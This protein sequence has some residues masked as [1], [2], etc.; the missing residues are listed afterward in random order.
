MGTGLLALD[1]TI[2]KDGWDEA[3]VVVS[4]LS[5]LMTV[6]TLIFLAAQVRD[7][8]RQVALAA[9]STIGSHLDPMAQ[10]ILDADLALVEHPHLRRHIY[11]D[12][13]RSPV[14]LPPFNSLERA[15]VMAMAEYFV[16]MLD[17]ELLRR[18]RFPDVH[19][20]LPHFEPWLC[21]LMMQSPA[22]CL[23][24]VENRQ[25]YTT[26]L[27]ARLADLAQRGMAALHV[28]EPVVIELSSPEL[29]TDRW[30]EVVAERQR[31]SNGT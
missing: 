13:N 8:R 4:A 12:D 30:Q 14:E 17:T 21:D 9:Q 27:G 23:V 24:A 16:D 3:A 29:L 22:A 5:A 31:P 19:A 6:G 10:R 20:S 28:P 18:D 2:A 1:V 7:A 26:G 25:W 15:S 11:G